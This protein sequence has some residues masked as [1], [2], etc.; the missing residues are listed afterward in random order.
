MKNYTQN[1]KM[2]NGDE[3][4]EMVVKY[5]DNAID[6]D[7]TIY[8]EVNGESIY[9]NKTENGWVAYSMGGSMSTDG[10][11]STMNF[12]DFEYDEEKQVYV[13]KDFEEGKNEQYIKFENGV[14]VSISGVSELL[15]GTEVYVT[16]EVTITNIGTTV[17][18]IPE[19]TFA[20]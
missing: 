11:F 10:L 8:T 15:E 14:L 9:I 13:N 7:G 4:I 2:T 3:S 18:E 16:I 20:E 17:V 12:N 1:M 6:M 19:Y 5:A